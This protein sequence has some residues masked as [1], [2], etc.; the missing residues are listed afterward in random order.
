MSGSGAP[1]VTLVGALAAVSLMLIVVLLS[2]RFVLQLETQIIVASFRCV[3]QLGML[4]VILYPIFSSNLP[5]VVLPY[6]LLM[7]TFAMREAHV[8]PKY[9]YAGMRSHF[10]AAIVAG[11]AVSFIVVTVLVIR[12]DPWWDAQ[13][14]V[15][16]CGMMLGGAHG[17]RTSLFAPTHI[18]HAWYHSPNP[19]PNPGMVN[20]LSLGIDRFLMSL[21]ENG[22]QLEALLHGGAT[23]R[24]AALPGIRQAFSTGLTPTLNT[25]NVIGLVSIPGMMTGQVLG[26]SP[27]LM[28]AKY[29]AVIMF[30]ICF[31]SAGVLCSAL[32]LAFRTLFDAEDRLHA[33][34]LVQ[35]DGAR[36]K[37]M[38]VSL[39]SSMHALARAVWHRCRACALS[40]P[41]PGAF[42]KLDEAQSEGTPVARTI[43]STG[44]PTLL[45]A[46]R[47]L[48][49]APA[50]GT[51][52][53][54][55]LALRG[56]A[57]RTLD[58]TVL[59]TEAS[60]LLFR[61]VPLVLTGPSGCGKSTVLK[62]LACLLPLSSGSIELDGRPPGRLGAARWR[63]RVCYVRQQGGAGL[64]GTPRDL[65]AQLLEL[66]TQQREGAQGGVT[67]VAAKRG[68]IAGDIEQ[69]TAANGTGEAAIGQ[70]ISAEALG[71]LTMALDA[72]GV[73]GALLDQ[74]WTSLS[75]GQSQRL[76]LGIMVALRPQVPS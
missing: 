1:D 61:H 41:P 51:G 65:Y 48:P 36:P 33:H 47:Q 37:D 11:L 25:M 71:A 68:D 54:P 40:S 5:H 16:L 31:T 50:D 66:G 19:N 20:S 23:A 58:G 12:P 21:I 22:A 57:V 45:G 2:R 17:A 52:E 4:G 18:H 59:V 56:A 28:A 34:L 70:S 46:F 62:A 24:E 35:R 74:A 73:G 60:L 9:G 27:P 30:L 13:T 15:P 6:L 39:V 55:L 3:L 43:P 53:V 29:Q 26:G 10:Y 8:K 14:M 67:T 42:R 72:I 44:A 38:L 76:Y 49:G 7:A 69:A 63:R 75:G 64:P 32:L